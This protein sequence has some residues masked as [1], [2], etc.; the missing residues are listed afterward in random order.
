MGLHYSVSYKRSGRVFSDLP[1]DAAF[2]EA[3]TDPVDTS[4]DTITDLRNKSY[5]RSRRH[6]TVNSCLNKDCLLVVLK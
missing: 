1:M 5:W 6:I 3:S 4:T 2:V